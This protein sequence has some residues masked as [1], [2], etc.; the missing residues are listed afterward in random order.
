MP[1]GGA[2]GWIER[3]FPCL[4]VLGANLLWRGPAAQSLT[5]GRGA[6]GT[7]TRLAGPPLD[8]PV[9]DQGGGEAVEGAKDVEPALVPNREPPK[10]REPS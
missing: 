6:A 10:A 7:S 4:L 2:P 3:H 9:A 1:P 5:T 8:E